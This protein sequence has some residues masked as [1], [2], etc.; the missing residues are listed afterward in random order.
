MSNLG[1]VPF[2]AVA[3]SSTFGGWFSDRL[4][5]HGSGVSPVR[6]TFV[7]AGLLG[8]TLL[9]PAAMVEDQIFAI[10][11]VTAA[12]L[13]FGLFSSNLWAV[14][15]TLAGPLAAGKWT[16]IQ[17]C[18]GNLAGIVAPYVTG[19][20]VAELHSFFWAFVL[21]CLA[22]VGGASCY[23]FIVEKVN[24]IRWFPEHEK[25]RAE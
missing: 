10:V 4:I 9:L 7:V 2:L 15:Q 14:T 5:R 16:G 8:A 20:I 25:M 22:L 3:L 12:C 19:W 17:N 11:L 24:P 13:A 1:S 18:C 6:K 23:L 21:V